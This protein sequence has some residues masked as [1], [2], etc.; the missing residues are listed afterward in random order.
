MYQQQTEAHWTFQKVK[1]NA[2]LKMNNPLKT[3][4]IDTEW[5]CNNT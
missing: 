3:W 2:Q 5:F 1:K 4:H